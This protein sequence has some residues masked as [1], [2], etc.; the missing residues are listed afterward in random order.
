MATKYFVEHFK[1]TNPYDFTSLFQGFQS[2]VR[3]MN[4]Q[5]TRRVTREEIKEV[6]F[7]I[8]ASSAPGADRMTGLFYQKY[9][10][11]V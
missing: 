5:M 4:N 2:K 7:S 9:W 11:V 3:A 10:E 6:V 1:S 8:K